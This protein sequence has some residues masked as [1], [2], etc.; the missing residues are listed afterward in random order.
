MNIHIKKQLIVALL[1][2]TWQIYKKVL[3]YTC[4]S[5]RKDMVIIKI[6]Q[7]VNGWWKLINDYNNYYFLRGLINPGEKPLLKL[8]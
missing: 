2:K 7:R 1:N 5:M 6:R 8:S 4:K 3:L